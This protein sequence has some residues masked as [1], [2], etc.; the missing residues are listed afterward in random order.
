MGRRNVCDDTMGFGKGNGNGNDNKH[1][2]KI[3]NS[4]GFGSSNVVRIGLR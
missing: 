3:G 4:H 2:L 1:E